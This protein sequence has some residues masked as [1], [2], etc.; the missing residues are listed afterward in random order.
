MQ[1]SILTPHHAS[2]YLTALAFI[3]HDFRKWGH[4]IAEYADDSAYIA[5][6]KDLNARNKSKDRRTSLK[7]VW[8]RE[9]I[10]Q[11][12]TPANLSGDALRLE[13]IS[14]LLRDFLKAIAALGEKEPPSPVSRWSP[15][16]LRKNSTPPPL[17][18]GLDL[19]T[20]YMHFL[21]SQTYVRNATLPETPHHNIAIADSVILE[22]WPHRTPNP[23][24]V[25][26]A[27]TEVA[28]KPGR[29]V[30]GPD[31]ST[32]TG[33]IKVQMWVDV[34]DCVGAR[35][36]GEAVEEPPPQYA[37][38]EEPPPDYAEIEG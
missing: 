5:T 19:V 6:I 30:E 7:V 11:P 13:K 2:P 15:K 22:F 25:A 1:Y 23:E 32:A 16:A 37:R 29:L 18:P 24:Q 31:R 10:N 35:D 27:L 12:P 38:D 33:K 21:K 34:G 17:T 26:R 3:A 4:S 36:G 20:R 28:S 14:A 9:V 8:A